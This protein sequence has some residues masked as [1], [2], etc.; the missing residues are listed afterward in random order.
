MSETINTLRVLSYKT[1]LPRSDGRENRSIYSVDV[2]VDG[3]I[4]DVRIRRSSGKRHLPQALKDHPQA[5]EIRKLVMD[6]V[7]KSLQDRL[8]RFRVL[9]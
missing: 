7:L 6:V 3:I 5:A 2:E 8:V 9:K 4:Y 1:L